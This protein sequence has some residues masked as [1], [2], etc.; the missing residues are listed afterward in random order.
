MLIGIISKLLGDVHSTNLVNIHGAKICEMRYVYSKNHDFGWRDDL[1]L[2]D[3]P[4]R[5]YASKHYA[6]RHHAPVTHALVDNMPQG[7]LC[8]KDTM[9][10]GTLFQ[11]GQ[12]WSHIPI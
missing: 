9:P 8:P 2:D 7:P 5:H 10:R 6:P 11:V 1:S 4:Q 3:T 12:P